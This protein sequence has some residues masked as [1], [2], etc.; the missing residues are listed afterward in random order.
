MFEVTRG[1]R[2]RG[3]AARALQRDER[4]GRAGGLEGVDRAREGPWRGRQVPEAA[5][6]ASAKFV[7]NHGKWTIEVNGKLDIKS[8]SSKLMERFAQMCTSFF[9]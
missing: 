8:C 7:E 3:Q 1:P 4:G 6:L 2:V 5:A 9:I